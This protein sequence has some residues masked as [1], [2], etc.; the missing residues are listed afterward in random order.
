MICKDLLTDKICKRTLSIHVYHGFQQLLLTRS[1]QEVVFKPITYIYQLG[2][3]FPFLHS[4][5][6][7]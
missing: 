3:Q 1:G 6:T 2:F 7:L 4:R 5:L